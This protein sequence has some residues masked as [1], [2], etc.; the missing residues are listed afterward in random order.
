MQGKSSQT[1]VT[2]IAKTLEQEDTACV[3][4]QHEGQCGR[5]GMNVR[6]GK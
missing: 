3:E 1:E 4:S 6:E 2:A 5:S